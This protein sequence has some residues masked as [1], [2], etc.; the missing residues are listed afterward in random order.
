MFLNDALRKLQK[1]FNLERRTVQKITFCLY[2]WKRLL[3]ENFSF[4]VLFSKVTHEHSKK[5]RF[6]TSYEHK[7]WG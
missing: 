1:K 2:V 3:P 6:S 7:E 5:I 4:S